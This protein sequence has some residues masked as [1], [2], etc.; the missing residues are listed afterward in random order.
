MPRIAILSDIHANLPAFI[1][2]LKEAEKESPDFILFGGDV[3]GY[4]A[5]PAECVKLVRDLG[6]ECVIGNHEHYVNAISRAKVDLDYDENNPVEA[7]I[8]HAKNELDE[9]ALEWLRDLPW[10]IPISEEIILAHATL[11]EPEE[12]HYIRDEELAQPTINVME[13]RDLK[14]GFF[15][16]VHVL[17]AFSKPGIEIK[18]DKDLYEIDPEQP[19]VVTVGS[20]GQPREDR[21]DN[22]ATWVMFDTDNCTVE[23]RRTEY[24]TIRAAKMILDAG[25]PKSSA[26]RL[27]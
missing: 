23:F 22:R 4:G 18:H 6:G 20:V 3:V 21:D 16:H 15:G 24:D 12:W 5:S 8:V 17:N 25:L 14:L 10:F 7:G 1:S 9:E 11:H 13:N 26:A 19:T 27:L 2:V